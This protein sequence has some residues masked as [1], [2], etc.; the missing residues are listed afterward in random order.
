MGTEKQTVRD[1]QLGNW[2]ADVWHCI[3]SGEA[4]RRPSQ[5]GVMLHKKDG[6]LSTV[7][8]MEAMS[9]NVVSWP[10][11]KWLYDHINLIWWRYTHKAPQR[12]CLRHNKLETKQKHKF[13]LSRKSQNFQGA[14]EIWKEKDGERSQASIRHLLLPIIRDTHGCLMAAILGGASSLSL[15]PGG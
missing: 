1:L 6:R 12:E 4:I 14:M 9:H 3:V 10:H 2:G 15:L 13:D 8:Q 11:V 5:P 7:G